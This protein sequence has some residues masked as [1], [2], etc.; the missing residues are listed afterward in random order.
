MRSDLSVDTVLTNYQAAVIVVVVV[1]NKLFFSVSVALVKTVVWVWTYSCV[2]A[3]VFL[4]SVCS[5][6]P[7]GGGANPAA[8]PSLLWSADRSGHHPS[9]G[10]LSHRKPQRGNE[11]TSSH[12]V[13]SLVNIVSDLQPPSGASCGS[14]SGLNFPT[15]ER[16]TGFLFFKCLKVLEFQCCGFK[17]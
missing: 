4:Q 17:V 8:G 6:Q 10:R 13:A 5:N 16:I 9:S 15:V 3:R 2:C 11:S 1:V 14:L 7:S 12:C